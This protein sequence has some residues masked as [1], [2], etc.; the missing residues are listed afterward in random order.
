MWISTPYVGVCVCACMWEWVKDLMGF[1]ESLNSAP[2]ALRHAEG[3]SVFCFCFYF[4]F[5]L[6]VFVSVIYKYIV[7]ILGQAPL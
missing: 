5:Y 4:Y 3:V 7:Q 1:A 2:T 6:F